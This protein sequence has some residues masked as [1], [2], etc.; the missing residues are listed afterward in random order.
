MLLMK[1]GILLVAMG[2]PN[3][4]RMAVALAATIK[5]GNKGISISVVTDGKTHFKE[6]AE[7][8]LFDSVIIAPAASYTTNGKIEFIK[9]KT[10]IY[11]FTPYQETLFLD[12]DIA[13]LP[14]RDLASIFEELKEHDFVMSNPG[15]ADTSK[16]K[17][18]SVWADPEEVLRAYGLK[19]KKWYGYHSEFIY[20]RK[21]KEVKKYFETAKKVFT[22]PK[23]ETVKFSG[24]TMADELAFMIA[25]M[26]L[27]YYSMLVDY[28]PIFWYRRHSEKNLRPYE[29]DSKYVG[30]SVGGNNA[31]TNI[32]E[33]YNVIVGAAFH[34]LGL[35]YPYKFINK[36]MFLPERK[37]I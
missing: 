10:Y 32:K 19:G 17:A 24:G 8:A 36:R 15:Y 6:E 22:T 37:T 11:D 3:Y 14:N 2:H 31:P 34:K 7:R 33:N 26:Q 28:L 4:F 29:F 21:C 23:V 16:E 30:Y 12:V 9:A 13:I 18:I 27:D 25:S 5:A 1:R 35:K 20:F